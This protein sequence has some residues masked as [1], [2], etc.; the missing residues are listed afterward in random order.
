MNKKISLGVTI[1]LMIIAI[2][3]SSAISISFVRNKYDSILNGLPQKIERFDLIDEL[4]DII[5]NNYYGKSDSDQ[6]I[7]AL[8][9]GYI[10][11][12][13]NG[14]NVYMDAEKYGEYLSEKNGEMSGIGIKYERVKNNIKVTKVFRNSPAEKA[15]LK[16][17]DL[18]VA[19]D[20]IRLNKS[21]YKELSSKLQGKGVTSVNLIYKR[22]KTD[23]NIT[24]SKGYE[25]QSVSTEVYENIGY[26]R[27]SDFYL[28]TPEQL[29]AETERFVSSGLSGI[30][31]DLR[32]N[33]SVN[34]EYMINSLDVFVPM[35]D[36]E[37]SAMTVF[38]EN[39]KVTKTFATT[40]GEINIPVAVL[41]NTQTKGAAEMFC[42]NMRD[43]G[44]GMIFSDGNTAGDGLLKEVFEL[45]SGG[46]I[47][48]TTGRVASYK[49]FFY[50]E[51]G[52]EPDY[53]F[54]ESEEAESLQND[55]QFLYAM[56]V[57]TG[58]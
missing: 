25:A 48:L 58:N 46:A 39:G 28:T 22:N 21:N 30:V 27:I 55:K 18:I 16:K 37:N 41:A 53:I 51:N 19:F 1:G 7:Q 36:A 33:E 10:S 47:L 6:L 12:L 2:A 9:A 56:S 35:S 44:K 42:I 5:N 3:V 24:V 38:D 8:A 32:D 13:T 49:G 40:P 50:D 26:I 29:K 14:E 34:Y 52:V 54:E 17:G 57:I 45:S 31:V 20:G 4:D 23:N 15:G 11:G 43:F